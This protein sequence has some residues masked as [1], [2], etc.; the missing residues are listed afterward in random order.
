M[1]D[2]K[3]RSE[4]TGEEID[5]AVTKINA[6]DLNNYYDK[7]D[8]NPQPKRL[9]TIK[10]KLTIKDILKTMHQTLKYRS[11]I[12]RLERSLQGFLSKRF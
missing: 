7:S 10:Q 4:Y 11:E 3:Y 5:A 12:L 6:L 8:I 2:K 9:I 1:V